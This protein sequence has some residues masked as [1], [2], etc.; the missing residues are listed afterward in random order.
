MIAWEPSCTA[1]KLESEP[2][3]MPRGV[4]AADTTYTAGSSFIMNLMADSSEL[5]VGSR[6]EEKQT[7]SRSP[8]LHIFPRHVMPRHTNKKED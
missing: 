6:D 5:L 8:P 1:L 4:L 7:H 3:N 2:W